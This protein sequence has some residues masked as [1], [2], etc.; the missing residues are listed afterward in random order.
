MKYLL[1]LL[2]PYNGSKSRYECPKC[3]SKLSFT[4]YLDGN[5][6]QIINELVGRCNHESACGYHYTPKQYYTDHPET[7]TQNVDEIQIHRL[8][9]LKLNTIRNVVPYNY[10]SSSMSYESDFVDFLNTKLYFPS[11]QKIVDEYALGATNARD[12]IFWQ[13]DINEQVRTGKIMRY[14]PVTG[15]RIKD[16]PNSINWV[17]SVL[18]KRG[19]IRDFNLEQCLFG[20]HLLAKYPLKSVCL[21]ESEKTAVFCSSIFTDFVWVATGGLSQMSFSKMSVLKGRDVIFF[22]DVDGY[23]KWCEKALAFNSMGLFSAVVSDILEHGATD[24]ERED[25]IDIADFLLRSIDN[26]HRFL[27]SNIPHEVK[28]LQIMIEKKKELLYL[29]K[30]LDLR[31][32]V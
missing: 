28:V 14:D 10:V 22:P 26:N 15:K 6:G 32:V 25:K 4:H 8:E 21:V 5:T 1:P 12:V 18:K 31:L 13:I 16:M 9:E 11:I 27:M 23:A 20:E 2:Q 7:A 29:M 19:D 24:K 17:H 30:K 3:K